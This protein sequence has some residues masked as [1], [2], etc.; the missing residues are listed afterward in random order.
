MRDC[1]KIEA[2]MFLLISFSA[3]SNLCGKNEWYIWVSCLWKSTEYRVN[4]RGPRIEPYG[5]PLIN[6]IIIKNLEKKKQHYPKFHDETSRMC[7]YSEIS[8]DCFKIFSIWYLLYDYHKL[9][10]FLVQNITVSH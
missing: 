10:N 5:I 1:V 9:G 6:M 2:A 8:R 7:Y 4:K 3:L